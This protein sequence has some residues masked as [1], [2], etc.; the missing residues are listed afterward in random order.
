MSLSASG[1]HAQV[2]LHRAVQALTP[3]GRAARH[4]PVLV[5]SKHLAAALGLSPSALRVRVHRRRLKRRGSTTL[6][7]ETVGHRTHALVDTTEVLQQ[8]PPQ[9]EIV[10][11]GTGLRYLRDARGRIRTAS[12]AEREAHRVANEDR[13]MCDLC[14]ALREPAEFDTPPLC[15]ASEPDDTDE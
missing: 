3:T 7:T 13:C 15:A 10:Q 9:R 4:S 1:A 14:R 2:V 8:R 11:H 5:P 6:P 12:M